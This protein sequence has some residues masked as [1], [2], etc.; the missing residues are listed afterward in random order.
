MVL[1]AIVLFRCALCSF[2]LVLSTKRDFFSV[3]LFDL[4]NFSILNIDLAGFL[5]LS[6]LIRDVPFKAKV[7]GVRKLPSL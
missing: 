4:L 7:I 1:R 6:I 5:N 3:Q 2:K